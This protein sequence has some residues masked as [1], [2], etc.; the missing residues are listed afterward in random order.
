MVASFASVAEFANRRKICT[1][2]PR[3]AS[4]HY[5]CSYN[6]GGRCFLSAKLVTCMQNDGYGDELFSWRQTTSGAKRASVISG[7]IWGAAAADAIGFASAGLSRT[8]ALRMYGYRRST[9]R[10]LPGIGIPSAATDLVLLTGQAV[11]NSKSDTALFVR[12]IRRRLRY[13][14]LSMPAS[15]QRTTISSGLRCW[16]SRSGE[17][18]GGL[19]ATDSGPL[20]RS[21]LLA[22]ILQGTGVPVDRWILK[23]CQVTHRHEKVVEICLMLAEFALSLSHLEIAHYSP[24]QHALAMHERCKSDDGREFWASIAAA[25]EKRLS[26]QKFAERNGWTNGIPST[27]EATTMMGIYSFMRSPHRYRF[28]VERASRLGG[29]SGTV[30]AIAGA[31]SGIALGRKGIPPEILRRV[32]IAPFYS[33][34]MN[35]F[36]ARLTSWPHGVEDI[37]TAPAQPSRPIRQFACRLGLAILLLV[38]RGVRI[39]WVASGWWISRLRSRAKHNQ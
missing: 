23:S 9:F 18:T 12:S 17:E 4:T 8:N 33:M 20:L 22:C 31:L 27:A 19:S 38:Q 15:A 30:A 25:I 13:Y 32:K 29:D 16:K 3:F 5:Q 7:C 24:Y 26:V 28:T 21:V 34:W 36:V 1:S 35:T 11:L 14:V 2:P 10:L 39:P 37:Q 6:R